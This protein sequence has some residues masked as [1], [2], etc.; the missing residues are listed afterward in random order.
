MAR[1]RGTV[2]PRPVKEPN[3]R[4]LRRPALAV[5][6]AFLVMAGVFF[7]LRLRRGNTAHREPGLSVLLVTVDTLRAD[8]LGCYGRRSAQT[9]WID[10]LAAT[11]VRFDFAHAHN[12]VTLPS[13]A[14]ILS[15]R[16]P[17]DHGVRDNAGFRL[18][19]TVDTLASLLRGHGYRTAA[20]VSA[21]PLDSRFGL[22][23]G[24]DVYDDRLGDAEGGLRLPDAGARRPE[25]GRRG[26]AWLQ[27]TKGPT[28]CWVHLYEPHAPYEPPFDWRGRVPT[29]Y[30]GEV[31]AADEA[32]G[33]L[34]G[35]LLD[36]GKDSDTLVV[37]TADHGEGLG[38]HGEA[39]HGVFAYE[40]T[41]RV[42]LVLHNPRPVR[43]H[44]WSR[45][46]RATSTSCRRSSTR[47]DLPR[48]RASPAGASSPSAQGV[49]AGDSP[50]ELLRDADARAHAGLGAHPRCPAGPP[51]V[52]RPAPPR[53]VR[54]RHGPARSRRTSSPGSRRL[55]RRCGPS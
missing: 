6:A 14:N 24:F 36:R 43:P 25:D 10:R 5:A 54:P 8:A 30:D 40:S 46:A 55:S 22:D 16:Y 35:P 4:S 32:L 1:R 20:F 50:A 12:V 45:R 47:S 7:G 31:T 33:P 53:A 52:P 9:P 48:P 21:F 2:P 18:P 19:P 51:Q 26:P 34:L 27:A 42:P 38:D 13:H 39:T 37:L 3:R 29:A 49:E 11:G 41:L 17:F 23:R 15:G 44:G 28:F